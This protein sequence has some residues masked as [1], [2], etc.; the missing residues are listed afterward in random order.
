MTRE[1]YLLVCLAEECAEVTQRATKALRFGLEEVQK[2]Q[3]EDNGERL[4][5]ELVDLITVAEL[6]VQDGSIPPIDMVRMQQ[7]KLVKLKK[8]MEYAKEKGTVEKDANSKMILNY[9]L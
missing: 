6:L 7:E 5:Y 3:D 1:Q 9:L 2:G 8:Y 4:A